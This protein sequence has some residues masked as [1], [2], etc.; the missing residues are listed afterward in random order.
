MPIVAADACQ[1]MNGI[2]VCDGSKHA[3]SGSRFMSGYELKSGVV[4][5]SMH[6]LAAEPFQGMN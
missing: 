3:Y 2:V 1:C 5:A 4:V 6:R